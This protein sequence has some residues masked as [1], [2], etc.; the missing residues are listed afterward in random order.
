MLFYLIILFSVAVDQASK[1]W[2]RTHLYLGEIIS[3][4]EPY[5]TFTYYLNSGAA[6]SSFQGYGR[7]FIPVGIFFVAAIFYYRRKGML[8]GVILESGAAFLVGGAIGNT[9]DR[10]LYGKV[11]DF[12]TFGSGNGVLNWADLSLNIGVILIFLDLI[13]GFIRTRMKKRTEVVPALSEE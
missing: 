13:I 4:W 7:Y 11:T 12:L 5:I 10:I 8:Q 2:I 6:G 9:V 1:I 3:T